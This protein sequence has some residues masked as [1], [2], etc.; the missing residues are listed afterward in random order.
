MSALTL[1]GHSWQAT[2]TGFSVPLSG[3]RFQF[4]PLSEDGGASLELLRRRWLHGGGQGTG[5]TMRRL[6]KLVTTPK[7]IVR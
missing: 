7:M 6:E 1:F 4:N 2:H 5:T 3:V